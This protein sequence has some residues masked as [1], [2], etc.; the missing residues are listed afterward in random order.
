MTE[1][2]VF[3]EMDSI[4]FGIYTPDEIMKQSV[5][6]IHTNKLNGPGS[7]ND[8][9]MGT[10]ENDK[11]C[12]SCGRDY[13]SCPGH[14]GHIELNYFIM[15]PM[16]H[17]YILNFLKCFCGGCYKL[18][19]SEDQ[20]KQEGF[21]K[22][23]GE[24]RFNKIL[25][26]LEKVEG[27]YDK[28]CKHPKPKMIYNAAEGVI[29][30]ILKK[31][32]ID[33]DEEG[34]RKIFDNISNQDVILLGFNPNLLHP[35]NLILS[36]LPVLPPASRPY[37]TSENATCD[38]DLT[39]QYMEI[40]KNNNHLQD[41]KLPDAKKTKYIQGLKFRIKTLMNNSQGKAKDTNHRPF[42]AI[43]E[44]IS[45]KEGLIRSNL[46]GKRVNQSGRTVIG[47]DPTIRT[48]E[49][50]V[51]EQIAAK[52]TIP[53]RVTAFNIKDLQEL[54]SKGKVNYIIR[55]KEGKQRRLN[56]EYILGYIAKKKNFKL[57]EGDKI[58]RR[59]EEI[60]PG[61]IE[62]FEFKLDDI[63]I[64]DGKET[65]IGDIENKDNKPFKIEIGD[66]IERQLQN[67]DILLLNRQPTLHKASMTA[68]RIIIRP[69]KTFRFSLAATKQFNADFDGDEMNVHTPQEY[70]ARAELSLLSTTKK[71]IM[72]SQASKPNLC[73]VQDSLLAAFLMTKDDTEIP[74]ETF[75]NICMKGD[76][77]DSVFILNKIKHIRKVQKELGMKINAFNGKG[78]VSLM[79][80][81]DFFY[82]KKND[83]HST[84]K[85]VKIYKGVLIEGALNKA[86]LGATHNSLI[87]IL[88]KEYNEDVCLDFINNIQFISNAWLLYHGFTISISDCLGKKT[89]EIRKS[90]FSAMMEAKGIEGATQHPKIKE[91]RINACLNKAKDVG[92]KIAKENMDP[93]NGFIATVTSGAK[94]D[95]FNIA[96]ITGLLGQ[97]NLTGQR[98]QPLLNRGK[99]TLPH[100]S[101]KEGDINREYES[102]GFIK[103]SFIH[104]LNPQEFWFHAMSG[105]EGVS[106]TAMKTA[107]SGYVQRKMI[108]MMEDIQV[109]YDGTVRNT[110]GNII[111]WA[112]SEDGMDRTNTILK[113]GKSEV[114]DVS[115]IINKLNTL[116]STKN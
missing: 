30:K 37:I 92:L 98:I 106:D 34:I 57:Q 111:Q 45:G 94:G 51:P 32:K 31:E 74:K 44:R 42:K 65:K 90:V 102:R 26:R 81:E 15:H 13:K 2:Q 101:F 7:L 95:F 110:C 12:G 41:D 54:V 46:L 93:K 47:P 66:I 99:R 53:E 116:H 25:E 21:L 14:F 6:K 70:D 108:K 20:L 39:M 9:R 71:V 109:R 40:I 49:L 60:D 69:Y 35:K 17:R 88:Y 56:M 82:N 50:V 24:A 76:N 27:C 64:R 73:I 48:D 55:E 38:D 8:E 4:I 63:L 58:K 97:Q 79:F 5:C 96:Q 77:W 22:Y 112:Y 62:D 105:R 11:N 68:K 78:L 16:Y 104:G 59:G 28:K 100:Y 85:V 84:E 10:L 113:E 18:L 1:Y 36:V 43:K 115:R 75:Y 29:K 89:D 103:N 23:K 86:N 91:A 67:G 80:P 72:N 107:S 52:L 33:L 19:L 114:M 61:E 83:A 3:K 87:Q